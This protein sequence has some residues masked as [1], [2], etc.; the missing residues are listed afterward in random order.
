MKKFLVYCL[1]ISLPFFLYQCDNNNEVLENQTD[2]MKDELVAV[3]TND[4]TIVTENRQAREEADKLVFS[5]SDFL[6]TKEPMSD[7]AIA[8]FD[9]KTGLVGDKAYNIE[10]YITALERV[11][12]NLSVV[13][14]RLTINVNSGFEL[15]MAEDLYL[16]ITN[17]ISKWNG[18]V[19]DGLFEIVQLGNNYYDIEPNLDHMAFTRSSP[20]D[21][22]AMSTHNA[23]WDAV[24]N[25]VDAAPIGTYVGEHF[26]MNFGGE[27]SGT[28]YV[29]NKVRRYYVCDA[30]GQHGI[31]DTG[32]SYN[33]IVTNVVVPDSQVYI[34]SLRNKSQLGIIT[35]QIAK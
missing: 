34:Y 35:Y 1:I 5:A 26:V 13:D 4:F 2:K 30:C 21:L 16:Y 6:Q 25:V 27:I 10:V 29:S 8:P 31:S 22:S 3:T 7:N 15:N 32:C 17:L 18:W 20:V 33:Y 24:K 11:Q 9:Y 12:K 28:F 19:E 14:G 23:R